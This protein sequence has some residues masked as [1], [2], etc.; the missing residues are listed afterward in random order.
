M[1]VH[2]DLIL[3]HLRPSLSS[4]SSS[5]FLF[6]FNNLGRRTAPRLGIRNPGAQEIA[7]VR[8]QQGVNVVQQLQRELR[9]GHKRSRRVDVVELPLLQKVA[10]KEVGKREM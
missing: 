6:P 3:L 1:N 8:P 2:D 5:S 9:Q 7:F 10:K 4:P